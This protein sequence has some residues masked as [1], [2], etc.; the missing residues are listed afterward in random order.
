MAE[1]FFNPHTMQ[2]QERDAPPTGNF[3]AGLDLG[4][5]SDYTALCILE[6]TVT[7]DGDKKI[8]HYA[9]RH[10]QRWLGVSYPDVAVELRPMLDQLNR[11]ALVVD[12]TGVGQAVVD[13][14]ARA[15]LPI[16]QL[17]PVSITA[18]HQVTKG[19]KGGYN[20][21]KRELVSVA[22]SAL[23]NR[24][25]V[26]ARQ[27]RE[28]ETLRRELSNFKVKINLNATES[29]EAWRSGDHDD[30]C[31]AACMA[32]WFGERGERQWSIHV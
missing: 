3:I 14:L 17:V 20:V 18:G 32:V 24:R 1:G 7:Q 16:R 11:P 2:W 19:V 13:I 8:R 27:L 5:V 12:S 28:A 23:Q 10:L 15:S 29:F 6:K 9:V 21:P 22:Q 30:L 26:I 25:L 31:L 4:Q